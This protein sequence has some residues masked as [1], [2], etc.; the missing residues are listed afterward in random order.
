MAGDLTDHGSRISTA[1][2]GW[3]RLRHILTLLAVLTVAAC[4]EESET[5]PSVELSTALGTTQTT[6]AERDQPRGC[7]RANW[8]APWTR[9]ADAAWV[10]RV[11][12]A[13]GYRVTQE[14]G[15]AP[16]AGNDEVTFH[17]WTT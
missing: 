14:G 1:M 12:N 11:V 8:P 13:A 10:R 5:R 9:C 2:T 17:V 15:S 3:T 6:P 7:P 16:V 4:S